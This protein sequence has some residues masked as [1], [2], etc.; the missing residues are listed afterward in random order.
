MKFLGMTFKDDEERIRLVQEIMGYCLSY[1]VKAQKMFIFKGEGSNGKS[2]LISIMIALAGGK[3]NISG[4]SL[5]NFD[6][7]FALSNLWNKT[8]NI[9]SENESDTTLGTENLQKIVVGDI[10]DVEMKF[11]NSFSHTPITK[12][13]FAL[14]NIP[15]AKEQSFGWERRLIIIP[16]NERFVLNPDPDN[17]N[18]VQLIPGKE[19][20]IIRD[21][22][23][24]IFL[25]AMEGLKR[26]VENNY[27]FTKSAQAEA[28][29]LDYLGNMNPYLKFIRKYIKPDPEAEKSISRIELYALFNTWCI[30]EEHSKEAKDGQNVFF[31]KLRDT[32][33]RENIKFSEPHSGKSYFYSG[34]RLNGIGKSLYKELLGSEYEGRKR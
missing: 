27:A 22:L 32:L 28:E 6:E 1:S 3:E 19:E 13:V 12:L 4:V 16:F 2:S 14:H 34:I 25:F 21:E 23:G 8:L 7:H 20:E 31:K 5:K 11:K 24:G 10:I 29:L 33:K 15:P 30:Q 26:L 18:E 17:E 9:S